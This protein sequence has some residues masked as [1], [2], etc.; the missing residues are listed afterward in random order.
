MTEVITHI[1]IGVC[2]MCSNKR[3][4]GPSTLQPGITVTCAK[5]GHVCTIDNNLRIASLKPG[6]AMALVLQGLPEADRG[7]FV[8]L[9]EQRY[10]Q[11]GDFQMLREIKAYHAR[12]AIFD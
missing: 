9:M 5:C 10:R 11:L 8:A 2:M 7:P 3:F 4:S 6:E 1:A 12:K